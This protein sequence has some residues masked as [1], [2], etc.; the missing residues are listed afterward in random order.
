MDYMASIELAMKNEKTEMEFYQNEAKRSNNQLA[1]KMF[2]KLADEEK[3]HMIRITE[4][5][6]KLLSEGKWPKD[7]PIQVSDT[8]VRQV[9]DEM[10]SKIGSSGNHDDDDVK[11]LEKAVEFEA[12]GALFY[13][14]LSRACQNPME[15][16]FFEFLSRIEREHQLSLADSLAYLKDPDGW[17]MQHERAGLDGA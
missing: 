11:A 4:L 12:K 6:D 5:N 15:K 13:S 10:V 1:G 14:E 7:I 16:N 8:N 17:M 3:E 9:L 2:S